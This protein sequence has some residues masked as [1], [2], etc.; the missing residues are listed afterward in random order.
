MSIIFILF[1]H[2]GVL[3]VIC[4]AVKSISRSK[5]QIFFR[6]SKIHFRPTFSRE[7]RRGLSRHGLDNHCNVKFAD[8]SVTYG[9]VSVSCCE[10]SLFLALSFSLYLGLQRFSVTR[11]HERIADPDPR[12]PVPPASLRPG[13][14]DGG[15]CPRIVPTGRARATCNLIQYRRPPRERQT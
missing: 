15:T 4:V 6:D 10:P 1:I 12:S 5:S 13:N 14:G 2:D 11:G 3:H 9:T 7:R 8:F